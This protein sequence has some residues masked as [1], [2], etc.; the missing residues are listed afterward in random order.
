MISCKHVDG[1]QT[2]FLLQKCKIFPM[3][4]MLLK[5]KGRLKK[6]TFFSK[7][8]S[9]SSSHWHFFLPFMHLCIYF[10]LNSPKGNILVPLRDQSK[11]RNV[12]YMIISFISCFLI[13]RDLK[14]EIKN[15]WGR[16]LCESHNGSLRKFNV[17]KIWPKLCIHSNI[18]AKINTFFCFIF[19]FCKLI[20]SW[21][22]F[23]NVTAK[24]SYHWKILLIYRF[25]HI[26][27][28]WE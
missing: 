20:V 5:S 11:V 21:F 8:F 15:S 6:I 27:C 24:R 10:H 4:K 14:F 23:L 28:S 9:F 12:L 1:F 22:S 13:S 17:S 2:E 26:P 19:L 25:E 7:A 16:I 3:R 18:M